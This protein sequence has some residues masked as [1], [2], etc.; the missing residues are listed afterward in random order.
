MVGESQCREGKAL[1]LLPA[2]KISKSAA[3]TTMHEPDLGRSWYERLALDDLKAS[4]YAFLEFLDRVCVCLL[5]KIIIEEQA[6][7]KTLITYLKSRVKHLILA[8]L[9]RC[10]QEAK[11]R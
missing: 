11:A 3:S 5:Y 6:C 7:Y 1:A 10:T 2:T 8:G 4:G 9:W